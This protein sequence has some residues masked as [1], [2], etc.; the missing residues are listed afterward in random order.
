MNI[1]WLLLVG[2]GVVMLQSYLFGAFNLKALTYKRYFSKKV[3]YEDESVEMV[4]II[5]NRKLLPVPWLRVESRIS[6]FLQFASQADLDINEDRYHKSVFYLAPYSQVKRLHQITCIHRGYYN[7]SSAAMTAGDLFGGSIKSASLDVGATLMVY[8]KIIDVSHIEY[9]SMRWQGDLVVKRWIMPDPFLVG[10]I[11]DYRSGDSMRDIHWGA[12][13]RMGTLQVKMHDYTA[14]PKLLVILNV[15][16]MEKQWGGLMDYEQ[17]V[18]EQGVRIAASLCMRALSGGVEVGF[19]SNGY[20]IGEEEKTV[21]VP[22]YRST[23]QAETILATM[24]KLVVQRVRTFPTLLE[25]ISYITD[26]DIIIISC[27]DSELIR[28]KV[29]LLK[30]RGN[31]VD[32]HLLGGERREEAS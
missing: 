1:I 11:R 16:A 27:Y 17:D 23:S 8:P 32:I 31:S 14:D 3:V 20:L 30:N 4:E 12:S 7:V 24:A 22:P 29:E 21:L 15:Q 6:P 28:Q 25:D 18:I 13:A 2:F 5:S 10:G 26:T 19:A 9:P